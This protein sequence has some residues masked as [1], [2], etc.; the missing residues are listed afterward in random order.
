MSTSDVR[1]IETLEG[2]RNGLL[3]LSDDWE[4]VLQEI[5]LTV[6]RAQDYFSNRVPTYWR[7][8]TQLAERELTEAKD[9][10]SQKMAA[11]RSS[12]RPS[13]IEAKKRVS[14]AQQR[15]NLCREKTRIAKTLAVEIKQQCDDMLGPL[16][17]MNEHCD[18]ILPAAAG[19]LKSL[20]RVLHDYMDGSGLTPPENG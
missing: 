19:E 10:L 13:A 16:A 2:L 1:N 3:G 7:A 5:R 17:D 15:L 14:L 8:Q 9:Y 20:L 12:D 18:T 6:H 11:A 4:T